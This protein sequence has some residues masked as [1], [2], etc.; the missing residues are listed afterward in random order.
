MGKVAEIEERVRDLK[1]DELAEFR[2]WFHEFD[3][4]NWDEQ[5][6]ADVASGRVG[7]LTGKAIAERESGAWAKRTKRL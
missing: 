5:I 4:R 2:S 7:R 3:A 1:P 6:A